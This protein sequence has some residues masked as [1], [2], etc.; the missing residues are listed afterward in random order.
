MNGK[1]E[2]E[3]HPYFKLSTKINYKQIFYNSETSQ[4]TVHKPINPSTTAEESSV[5]S[6]PGD[7]APTSATEGSSDAA[8]A[9]NAS[10]VAADPSGA[11]VQGQIAPPT[12]DTEVSSNAAEQQMPAAL[13]Q[14]LMALYMQFNWSIPDNIKA[15]SKPKDLDTNFNNLLKHNF[16][17]IP[18]S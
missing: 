9:Q 3:N 4:Y 15:N 12:V 10:T 16:W 6:V 2:N 13:A 11:V 14:H 8:Q 7:I 18:Q 17:K 5:P 1:K